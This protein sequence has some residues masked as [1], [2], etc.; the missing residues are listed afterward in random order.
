M[1]TEFLYSYPVVLDGDESKITSVVLRG[2]IVWD[3]I[4]GRGHGHGR[5]WAHQNRCILHISH[6]RVV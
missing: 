5:L 3:F 1:S 4:D 6:D 2:C